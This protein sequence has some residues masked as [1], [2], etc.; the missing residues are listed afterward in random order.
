MFDKASHSL[1][2]TLEDGTAIALSLT[3]SSVHVFALELA[4][5]LATLHH[6]PSHKGPAVITLTVSTL[7]NALQHN[8]AR[9][10]RAMCRAFVRA[11]NALAHKTFQRVI[12]SAL[13]IPATVAPAQKRTAATASIEASRKLAHMRRAVGKSSLSAAVAVGAQEP[14]MDNSYSFNDVPYCSAYQYFCYA[15][16]SGNQ[17][18][19]VS[20]CSKTTGQCVF[21]GCA[22]TS[23]FVMQGT[24]ICAACVSGMV[25]LDGYCYLGACM[26]RGMGHMVIV[27]QTPSGP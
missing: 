1:T 26:W 23:P 19:P 14:V 16:T 2:V 27:L 17:W 10:I 18:D 3:E 7:Q 24:Q 22:A 15:D 9:A 12:V 25:L 6:L 5:M 8:D 11:V 21:D 13:V 4:A 20:G